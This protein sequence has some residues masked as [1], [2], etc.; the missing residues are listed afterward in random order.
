MF[1]RICTRTFLKPWVRMTAGLWGTQQA[2]ARTGRGSPGTALTGKGPTRPHWA[3]RSRGHIS[4]GLLERG[5]SLWLSG[6]SGDSHSG[7]FLPKRKQNS[8]RGGRGGRARGGPGQPRAAPGRPTPAPTA[9]CSLG[10]PR[11]PR[12]PVL[13]LS[14]PQRAARAAAARG[15]AA[16][17]G[18]LPAPPGESLRSCARS[19][20]GQAAVPYPSVFLSH[21]VT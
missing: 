18:R 4:P 5:D 17:A 6:S 13:G 20:P 9:P 8:A 12:A 1:L 16:P 3:A 15:C 7:S 11:R 14:A 10:S 19:S 2:A 21:G